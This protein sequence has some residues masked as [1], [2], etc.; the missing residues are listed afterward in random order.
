MNKSTILKTLAIG[1]I[2]SISY[3]TI[4]A[5]YKIQISGSYK[6]SIKI[7]QSTPEEVIDWEC[8]YDRLGGQEK[9]VYLNVEQGR[10]QLV[11]VGT[12]YTT[13]G[14]TNIYN[15]FTLETAPEYTHTVG[16][17]QY[18]TGE[19]KDNSESHRYYEICVANI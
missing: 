3:S 15:G 8:F 11:N 10:I 17:L 7:V 18:R 16:D 13:L 5:E 9:R 1:I 12:S 2:A 4:A 14:H 19:V 6:D